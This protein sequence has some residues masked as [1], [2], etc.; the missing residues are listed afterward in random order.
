MPPPARPPCDWDGRT[1]RALLGLTLSPPEW[2]ATLSE[3]ERCDASA[4]RDG[5]TLDRL[6]EVA[7]VRPRAPLLLEIIF[8]SR[9]RCH[10]GGFAGATFV[11]LA[12]L[13]G[14]R[15][16]SLSPVARAALLWSIATRPSAAFRQL[17]RCVVSDI[18]ALALCA[19]GAGERSL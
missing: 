7:R 13:W 5:A 16:A 14:R 4:Y 15:R 2:A 1:L 11:D 18:E 8:E 9:L 3:I 17:E 10:A 19:F 6:V 12:E